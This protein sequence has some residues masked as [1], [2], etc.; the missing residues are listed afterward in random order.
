MRNTNY[1]S[2]ETQV[3]I[4]KNDQVLCSSDIVNSPDKGYGFEWDDNLY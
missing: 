4:I 2:P 3:M 1:V